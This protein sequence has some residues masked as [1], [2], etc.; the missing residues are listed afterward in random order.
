MRREYNQVLK[1]ARQVAYCIRLIYL[2]RRIQGKKVLLVQ[3]IGFL[4]LPYQ[5]EGW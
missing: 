3:G 4:L 1:G 5:D 2:E